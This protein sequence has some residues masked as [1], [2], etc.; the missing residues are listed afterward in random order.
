[1]KEFF[2][3]GGAGFIGINTINYILK[4]KIGRIIV[5][6]NF[7][8]TNYKKFKKNFSKIKII[9][10]DILDKK[11]LF[12][13]LKKNYTII[14][15][16]ANSD[17][18]S[19]YSNPLKDIN[20]NLLGMTNLLESMRLKGNKEIIFTSGSGV[21]GDTKDSSKVDENF[22]VSRPISIYGSTKLG[23]ESLLSAYSYFYNINT[24]ILRPCNI[25]GKYMTH[26]VIHDL[27]IK[28]KKN[29]KKLYVLGNGD[30]LK[31]YLDVNDLVKAFFLKH[32]KKG[33]FICFNISNS[34]RTSVKK[35]AK[36]I[37]NYSINKKVK[38]IYSKSKTGWIGD[39]P[40]IKIKFDKIKKFGWKPTLSS[41]SAV[42][43]AIKNFFEDLNHFK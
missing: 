28:L 11:K 15:L 1:M 36:K 21:Y 42:D 25:V 7:S 33:N 9:K 35:I 22:D 31:P 40:K 29:K 32:K 5:Y 10:G 14:H 2:I 30:Q 16:A 41:D 3:T 12:K 6:D 17:I 34:S 43:N 27:I 19:G 18:S 37:V 23:S 20:I 13:S 26:G 24:T 38:I 4:K 8:V 39:V